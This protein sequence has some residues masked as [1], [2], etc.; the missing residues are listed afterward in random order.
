MA[1]VHGANI[2]RASALPAQRPAGGI[3]IGQVL[4]GAGVCGE[5]RRLCVQRLRARTWEDAT[6]ILPLPTCGEMRYDGWAGSSP[7]AS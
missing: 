5:R 4:Q 3:E 6:I 7:S 2:H 1:P